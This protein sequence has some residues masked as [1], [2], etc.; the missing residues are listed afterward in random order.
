MIDCKTVILLLK[1]TQQGGGNR[2]PVF[3]GDLIRRHFCGD[4]VDLCTIINGK[5]GKCGENCKYCAQ[6]AHHKTEIAE[7][8]YL[9]VDDIV[10]TA[11][12]NELQGVDRFAIVTAGRG[13]SE[14]DFATTVKAY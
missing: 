6:S 1:K 4:K 12:D 3:Y 10:K 8:D 11:L 13:L 5:S 14:Q 2:R 9:S 7:Y